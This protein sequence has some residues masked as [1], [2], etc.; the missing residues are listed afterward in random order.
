MKPP[1]ATLRA[2]RSR[3]FTIV[4]LFILTL[5]VPAAPL[6]LAPDEAAFLLRRTGFSPSRAEIAA[7]EPL[8]FENAVDLILFDVRTEPVTPLPAWVGKPAASLR[9]QLAGAP[10]DDEQAKQRMR[11]E[12]QR[13]RREEA[14]ELKA[15]WYREM[16]ATPSPFTERMAL[17]WHNH[18]TSSLQKVKSPQLMQRQNALL[19]AG[20]LGNLRDLTLAIAQD[21]AMLIYLDNTSNRKQAPNENFARELLELFTL[22]EGHYTEEDVK[23]AARAFTGW[24]VDRGEG[25]YQFLPARHD[26]GVKQF[27]GRRGDFDGEQIIEILFE[28]PQTAA[29]IV[30]KLW[31]E[32]ISPTPDARE[33]ERLSALFREENYELKPLMR[34]LLLTPAL[35]DP[36]HRGALVKSPVELTVGTVRTFGLP[37]ADTRQL[38][39]YGREL[40]QDILDP[41]NVKGWPGGN[42]WIDSNTLL[43]RRQMLERA[44]RGQEA[45]RPA[46]AAPEPAAMG[47]MRAEANAPPGARNGDLQVAQAGGAT[48]ERMRARR[49][50]EQARQSDP[51]AREIRATRP[52]GDVAGRMRARRTEEQRTGRLV[53][54]PQRRP[55]MDRP[56]RADADGA[57]AMTMDSAM[58]NQWAARMANEPDA[59]ASLLLAIPPVETDATAATA[60]MPEAIAERVRSLVL[61]PAYQLK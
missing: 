14:Q 26:Y 22:G 48:A 21:P 40:G 57:E 12:F 9:E 5:A 60:N 55:G 1:T 56:P 61:D 53:P 17:F 31:R 2:G 16:I 49:L 47:E 42:A 29:Y 18:F 32:F 41:P 24:H 45:R 39:R 30:E 7:L 10:E 13:E 19:R 28:Q 8:S 6:A 36:A 27:L 15:W 58:M 23:Q 25:S 50:A 4:T 11:A 44:L 33:V 35:R 43:A 3:S 46:E 37:I 38:V 59:L 52:G 20:A 51:A 34:A 54:L